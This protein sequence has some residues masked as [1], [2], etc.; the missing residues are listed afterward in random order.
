MN[1]VFYSAPQS[2]AA[3]VHSTL[4]EL[5]VPHERVVLDFERGDQKKPA[6]AELNP[7]CKGVIDQGR[8]ACSRVALR[9]DLAT[10]LPVHCS[11]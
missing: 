5:G 10:P 8:D 4:I 3:P 11:E 2:S 1:I 6:Y 9:L 7:N